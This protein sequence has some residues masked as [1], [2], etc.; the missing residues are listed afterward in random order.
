MT[1]EE[2]LARFDSHETFVEKET[3]FITEQLEYLEDGGWVAEDRPLNKPGKRHDQRGLCEARCNEA[4][5]R[6]Q[7]IA[8]HCEHGRQAINDGDGDKALAHEHLAAQERG[9]V[10]ALIAAIQKSAKAREPGAKGGANS[11]KAQK[12]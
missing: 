7:N 1:R 5:V 4:A 2:L 10:D 9:L 8:E 3:P 11:W 6:L 12:R